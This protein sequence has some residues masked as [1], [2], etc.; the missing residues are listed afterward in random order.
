MSPGPAVLGVAP[1]TATGALLVALAASL[2]AAAGGGALAVRRARTHGRVAVGDLVV[3]TVAGGGLVLALVLVAQPLIG[4]D[5]WGVAHVAYRLAVVGLPVGALVV[6]AVVVGDR[7]DARRRAGAAGAEGSRPSAPR[8]GT[9]RASS[10]TG[11]AVAVLALGVLVGPVGWWASTVAPDRLEV[12][13]PTVALVGRAGREPLRIGVL[14][15]L[16]TRS[17]GPHEQEAVDRLLAARPD[18]ILVPGDVYQGDPGSLPDQ[19]GALHSLLG[20][21]HAPGGVYVVQGDFDPPGQLAQI[22]AGTDARLLRDEVVHLDVR[23]RRVTLA[24]LD[25]DVWTPSAAAALAGLDADRGGDD[26]RIVVAHRPDAVLRLPVPTRVD[27]VVAGHTHGGQI[28][29][30]VLGPP[31]TLSAVPRPVAAGGLHEVDGRRIFVSKGVGME[32]GQAPPVRLGVTPDI[33]I[34]TLASSPS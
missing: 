18:L 19:L 27:L 13:E 25:L 11:P 30:P 8:D 12:Q 1:L 4:L 7:R 21:L 14:A 3:G 34:I 10:V 24:G 31:L 29:L 20:R 32:R 33:G 15:D 9:G 28:S 17:V 22:F 6:L 5:V 23:D 16:Q 26:I 2:V